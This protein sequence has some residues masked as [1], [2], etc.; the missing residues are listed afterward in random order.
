MHIELQTYTPQLCEECAQPKYTMIEGFF[1]V[2]FI[3][4]KFYQ[5]EKKV[6]KIDVKKFYS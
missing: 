3:V 2:M 5:L 4:Y 6:Y 1:E